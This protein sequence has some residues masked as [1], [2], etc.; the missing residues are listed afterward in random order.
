[1]RDKPSKLKVYTLDLIPYDAGRPLQENFAKAVAEGHEDAI[2]LLLEHPHTY[3]FGRRGESQNLL[4]DTP[5]LDT[6]A[7]GDCYWDWFS[8]EGTG[9]YGGVPA[10]G[11]DGIWHVC[12]PSGIDCRESDAELLTM[13]C[14]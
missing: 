4:W 9:W 3:T 8:C 12:S 6:R 5:E 11:A 2:L 7:G 10:C 14:R 1:M 13:P